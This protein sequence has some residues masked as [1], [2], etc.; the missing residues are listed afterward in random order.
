MGL[1]PSPAALGKDPA[2]ANGDG[3]SRS[4]LS[5]IVTSPRGRFIYSG[6][7]CPR[8]TCSGVKCPGERATYSRVRYSGD[9]SLRSKV[10]GCW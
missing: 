8:T 5:H 7:T 9:K 3:L 10:S 2:G 6:V 1:H 4:K